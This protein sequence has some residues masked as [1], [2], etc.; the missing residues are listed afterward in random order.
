M[1]KSKGFTLIELLVVIAIIALLVSILLPS[2]NR[3]RELTK[4]TMCKSNLSSIGKGLAVWQGGQAFSGASA[5]PKARTTFTDPTTNT[6]STM[7]D[8]AVMV[9]EGQPGGLFVCPS[10]KGDDTGQKLYVNTSHQLTDED[11]ALL[12]ASDDNNISYS[13]HSAEETEVSPGTLSGSTIVLADREGTT[14]GE[15]SENHKQEM[16]NALTA[17]LYVVQID[18]IDDTGTDKNIAFRPGTKGATVKDNIYT[19]GGTNESSGVDDSCV[20]STFD[21]TAELPDAP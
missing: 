13:Y 16:V 19:F 10:V 6:D 14:A 3:V 8:L 21:A 20:K 5:W 2:L 4:R 18:D 17:G 7:H 15:A 11:G 12:A 9:D 1:K